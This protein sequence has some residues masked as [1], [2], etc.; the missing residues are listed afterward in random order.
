MAD[1]GLRQ[2]WSPWQE[3]Y[4]EHPLV[5]SLWGIPQLN[6]GRLTFDSIIVHVR[7]IEDGQ[8]SSAGKVSD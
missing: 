7:C 1:H 8:S 5:A 2:G 6:Q 4:L 3:K